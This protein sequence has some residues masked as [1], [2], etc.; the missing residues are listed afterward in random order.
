M[1]ELCF[2]ERA[3]PRKQSYRLLEG[4]DGLGIPAL[5]LKDQPKPGIGLREILI[6]LD[7]L[8]YLI[9]GLVVLARVEVMPTQMDVKEDVEWTQFQGALALDQGFFDP[10]LRHQ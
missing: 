4:G 1:R 6:H 2:G 10:P 5:L 9:E 3:C 8:F 7:S